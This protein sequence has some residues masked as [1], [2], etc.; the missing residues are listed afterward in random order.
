MLVGFGH[1]RITIFDGHPNH[2]YMVAFHQ[3]A[4][5]FYSQEPGEGTILV[6]SS[7]DR[8]LATVG[9]QVSVVSVVM[10]CYAPVVRAMCGPVDT[11]PK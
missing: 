8:M 3:F 7:R 5:G 6:L 1:L 10:V 11:K 4:F 9:N 2:V